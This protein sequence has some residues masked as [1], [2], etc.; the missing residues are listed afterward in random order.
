MYITTTPLTTKT[1]TFHKNT[2]TNYRIG[3]LKRSSSDN[4]FTYDTI[5]K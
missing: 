1:K 3:D 5:D 2:N 4:F